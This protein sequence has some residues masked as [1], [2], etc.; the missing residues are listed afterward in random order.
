M[1][2]IFEKVKG[3]MRKMAANSGVGK[4]YR[5]VFDLPTVPPFREFYNFGILPWHLLYRGFYS[6]WHSVLAPTIADPNGKRELSRM[7]L[8]KAIS[9]ELASLIWS[10]QCTV[11]VTRAGVKLKQ[12]E[13]D[14][15]GDFINAVLEDNGFDGKMQGS[16]EQCAALGGGALKVWYE[17][18]HDEN[19]VEVD[20]KIRIGYAMADQFVP[21][22]WDNASIR[23][24]VF[25][26][27]Q[28]KDGYYWTRLEWHKWEHN[29]Y[30]IENELYRTEIP[31]KGGAKE[32]Q[33]ILGYRYPLDAVYPNLAERTEI[34][35]L[36]KPLFSYY[37]MPVAN[38][39][40]DNSPL[41][42]SVY[43]NA[44]STL[45]A[46]D[47]CYDSLIREFRL[48]KKRIIV[49]A[50]FVKTVV[51]PTTGQ[52]RRYFDASDETYEALNIDDMDALKITDNSVS[53]RVEEHIAAI[54]AFLS[55]LCLQVGLSAGT[56]T[57][58]NKNGLRTATEVVSENSKTYKTV[59]TCQK[60]VIIAVEKLVQNIIAV[61]SLY[62]VEW[63][64]AKV[65]ALAAGGYECNVQFDDGIIQDRKTN[66]EE[67]ILLTSNGLMSKLR[68]LTDP[69]YGQGLT[70]EQALQE[71]QDIAAEGRLSIEA[72]D[73][74]NAFTAE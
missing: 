62:D 34:K 47:I 71:L 58:D 74:L 70:K 38:N 6:P 61:A 63:Q 8:P 39:I 15:L 24:A 19:G 21:T 18:C 43:A 64:G 31:Q 29:T 69:K 73:R 46:L 51:D 28:A 12:G 3:V 50:R 65:A 49:P 25:S 68:F 36:T 67:G 23:A 30:V 1:A 60:Q 44:L 66:I 55:V 52:Q 32:N 17:S 48:G 35:G 54:N 9:A 4:E 16:I 40:D 33:D 72:I 41:G 20:G 14:P 13:T 42:V 45:H 37:K 7:D 27:R 59:K 5:D 11:N 26:S 56:F 22:E 2:N 10:E 57:F 53:L